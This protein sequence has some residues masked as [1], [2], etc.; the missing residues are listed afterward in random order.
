MEALDCNLLIPLLDSEPDGPTDRLGRTARLSVGFPILGVVALKVPGP[1]EPWGNNWG[2][3]P[4]IYPYFKQAARTMRSLEVFVRQQEK[5]RLAT[6]GESPRACPGEIGIRLLGA[7]KGA[8]Q[9]LE[10]DRDRDAP[11]GEP[12]TERADGHFLQ[13][14]H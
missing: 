6:L 7:I 5:E 8:A 12:W 13:D 1:P 4:A 3:L 11:D 9:F 14:H 2:F 10:P